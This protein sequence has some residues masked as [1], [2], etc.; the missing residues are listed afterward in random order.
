MNRPNALL[1]SPQSDFDRYFEA[2]PL[3]NFAQERRG[4]GTTGVK[5]VH[6][7]APA[8]HGNDPAT[9][10]LVIGLMLGGRAAACWAWDGGRPNETRARLRGTLGV[11]PP[12][13]TARFEV[14]GPSEMLVVALPLVQLRQRLAEEVAVPS[15]FGLLHD[16]Y[17]R[18]QGLRT[19]CLRLWR[20][21]K[22]G[23][24]ASDLLI[25]ALAE[26]MLVALAED[27]R[28]A[29]LANLRSGKLSASELSR[30]RARAFEPDANV[31][32]LACAAGLPVRT[33]R[34]SFAAT[35]GVS[36]HRWLMHLKLETAT[37]LLQAGDMT[38]AEIAAELEFASQ[39]HLTTCFTNL[40]AV[41]PAQFRRHARGI[42]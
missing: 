39:A 27:V 1:T 14:S 6:V 18:K 26:Q 11:T 5:A 42:D 31:V 3:A 8:H 30:V 17:S 4:G 35:I 36:P 23:G 9:E 2:G 13:A 21:A 19:L 20:A 10:D 7:C 34:R 16:T 24:A 29:P 25:D 12:G 33:F 22:T 32:A 28:G 37:R 38:I 40:Y 41:S 15:D